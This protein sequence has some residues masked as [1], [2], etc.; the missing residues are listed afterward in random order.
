[1]H[2]IKITDAMQSQTNGIR[3]LI[4]SEYFNQT[5]VVPPPSVQDEIV[6]HI[7]NLRK[8]AKTLQA[9]ASEILENAK[10]EV[11]TT[12][13]GGNTIGERNV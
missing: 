1:M 3:N 7:M 2:N 5:I 11:E 6:N 8:Q 4:M 9:E 10:K 12:I 13:L